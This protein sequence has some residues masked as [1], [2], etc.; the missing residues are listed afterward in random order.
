LNIQDPLR[1]VVGADTEI[2]VVLKWDTDEVGDGILGFLGQFFSLGLLLTARFGVVW[3][4]GG[5]FWMGGP[6]KSQSLQAAN[7]VRAVV[8]ALVVGISDGDT[9]K[10]FTS[11]NQ[12]LRTA[13]DPPQL[14]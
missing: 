10:A 9:V 13:P 6:S 3:I 5:E 4:P 8:S 7:D 11:G 12:L 1:G 2:K 14:D